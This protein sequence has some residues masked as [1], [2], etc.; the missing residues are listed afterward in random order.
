HVLQRHLLPSGRDDPPQGLPQ[1]TSSQES[2]F[3]G[4]RDLCTLD[5]WNEAWG[6]SRSSPETD[7]SPPPPRPAGRCAWTCPAPRLRSSCAITTWSCCRTSPSGW[8]RSATTAP[9]P[10]RA[11]GSQS[12]DVR[13]RRPDLA[14]GRGGCGR[15]R[16]RGT[17]G[18]ARRGCPPG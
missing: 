5:P 15:D 4:F 3:P 7:P 9:P 10:P 16:Q 2:T 14:D 18:K 8:S 12:D 1:V 17:R 6:S 13:G 11:A